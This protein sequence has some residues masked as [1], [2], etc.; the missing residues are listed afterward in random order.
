MDLDTFCRV[1]ASDTESPI[2]TAGSHR[3]QDAPPDI[4]LLDSSNDTLD[5]GQT[6]PISYMGE[7]W[8]LSFVLHNTNNEATSRHRSVRP[9]SAVHHESSRISDY[10]YESPTHATRP[11]EISYN[12]PLPESLSEDICDQLLDAYF[13]YFQPLCPIIDKDPFLESVHARTI[14]RTLLLSVCFIA[15]VH[16]DMNVLQSLGYQTRVQAGDDLFSKADQ[17]LTNDTDSD[18][19]TIMISSYLLHYWW[20]KPVKFDDSLWRL[21]GVIR[22]GQ[23]LGMHH[24]TANSHMGMGVRKRWKRLWWLLYV[25]VLAFFRLL[26]KTSLGPYAKRLQIRDRQ[27][28]L[29]LGM[30]MIIND[31]DCTLEDLTLE[32][33]PSEPRETAQYIIAQASLSRTGQ[34]CHRKNR[35]RAI[36]SLTKPC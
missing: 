20:G 12:T 10:C 31:D 27:V 2:R 4:T 29:C 13:S 24:S 22:S 32:D 34:Y 9:S 26:G 11:A 3:L 7:S 14:S 23:C 28:S 25:S 1:N 30:P 6:E 33:F 19:I 21:S 17:A 8:F 15:S 35:S 5:G 36:R 16:C 18:R